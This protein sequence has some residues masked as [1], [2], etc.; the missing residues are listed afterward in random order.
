TLGTLVGAHWQHQRSLHP[1][2]PT[3]R[4]DAILGR[5]QEAGALGG[6]ALGA[7]GGGCVLLIAAPGRERDVRDAVAP[8]AALVDITLDDDGATW[9][10]DADS[11]P[12]PTPNEKP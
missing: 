11:P 1:A 2:I 7:S 3:L 12:L 4:I 10:H 8:L 5:G 9:W 6:K